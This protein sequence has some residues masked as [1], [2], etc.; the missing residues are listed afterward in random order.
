MAHQDGHYLLVWEEVSG[1]LPAPWVRA[2][3]SGAPNS[4]RAPQGGAVASPSAQLQS[5][6]QAA[7]GAELIERRILGGAAALL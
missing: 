1:S 2:C 4:E 3:V 7:R 6:S 5:G